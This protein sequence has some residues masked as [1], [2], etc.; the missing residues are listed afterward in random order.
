MRKTVAFLLLAAICFNSIG[1]YLMH[2]YLQQQIKKEIKA[3]MKQSVPSEELVAVVLNS[4]NSDEFKWIHSKEFRYQGIMYDVISMDVM[5][6]GTKLLYCITDKQETLLFKNLGRYVCNSMNSDPKNTRAGS[7][8]MA[9][10]DSLFPPIE[11]NFLTQTYEKGKILNLYY[12][13]NYHTPDLTIVSPP[14]QS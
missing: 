13:I 6:D 9:F 3:M 7:M 12:L 14:P 4:K 10:L 2:R 8:L 1:Y 11:N 5:K